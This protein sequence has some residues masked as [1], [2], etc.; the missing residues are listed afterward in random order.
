M[1]LL[2][3]GASSPHIVEARL[4]DNVWL[5]DD[6]GTRPDTSDDLVI[7]GPDGGLPY[8]EYTE[9]TNPPEIRTV[10]NIK[11]V[12]QNMTLTGYNLLIYLRKDEGP[13]AAAGFE[14]KTVF[15][16]QDIR[17]N[18]KDVGK[19]GG[20]MFGSPRPTTT[21]GPTPMV[22]RGDGLMQ[23]DLPRKPRSL[24]ANQEGPP[25][26]EGPTYATFHRNVEVERGRI[27]PDVLNCP[28]A[29][30]LTLFPVEKTV[31]ISPRTVGPLG[32]LG[33][34][35]H[36]PGA[37]GAY[38][39]NARDSTDGPLGDLDLRVARG[40][41]YAVWINSIAQGLNA[42]CN[43]L[44]YKKATDGSARTTTYLRADRTKHV[45]VEKVD[46]VMGSPPIAGRS[47]LSQRSGRRTSRSTT[48]ARGTQPRRS[49]PAGQAHTRSELIAIARSSTRRPGMTR[50]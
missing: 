29:L 13:G 21:S 11:L 1:G 16:H 41:G 49:S 23:I 10:S 22:L 3:S 18:I 2:K 35:H 17:I 25:E 8:M 39:H 31:I 44:I 38:P 19:S 42:R 20:S 7:S 32:L 37:G 12:D 5:R 40:T 43:E 6:K 50:W 28:D 30:A 45:D 14:A 47:R 27:D 33:L 26:Y 24:P 9:K 4:I 34:A 36:I 15:L 48:T 46:R